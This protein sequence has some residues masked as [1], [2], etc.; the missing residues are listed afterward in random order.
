MK[1]CFMSLV[2][3][4]S[5]GFWSSYGG[6]NY[7]EDQVLKYC[8]AYM[9]KVLK[10][11]SQDFSYGIERTSKKNFSPYYNMKT[12]V[13]CVAYHKEKTK[14]Y[15]VQMIVYSSKAQTDSVTTFAYAKATSRH[16]KDHIVPVGAFEF[17]TTYH[18]GHYKGISY[19]GIAY[20]AITKLCSGPGFYY[21]MCR[22]LTDVPGD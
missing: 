13:S 21:R 10:K 14:E 8:K 5:L 20:I 12:F 22:N 7:F 2:A 6:A 9:E 1:N 16:R 15:T 11:D 3:C 19:K 4:L 18:G 17:M